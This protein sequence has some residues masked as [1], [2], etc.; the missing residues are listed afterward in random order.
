MRLMLWSQVPM[1]N[2]GRRRAH[3]L[4]FQALYRATHAG[5]TS[6]RE[7]DRKWW[8]RKRV[9]R[10]D[11]TMI[12]AL[13]AAEE[14]LTLEEVA[15]FSAGV[16]QQYSAS[17]QSSEAFTGHVLD[18]VDAIVGNLGPLQPALESMLLQQGQ[19]QRADMLALRVSITCPKLGIMVNVGD[20]WTA[21]LP[22]PVTKAF[23]FLE[24]SLHNSEFLLHPSG[25]PCLRT[26]MQGIELITCNAD[27]LFR[28]CMR[29][30]PRG[31]PRAP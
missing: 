1:Q 25:V 27:W 9:A 26:V 6:F 17:L 30:S 23:T 20:A 5:L 29:F 12:R 7:L 2:M 22:Q 10:A 11:K 13:H 24:A 16:A 14:R 8:Q 3:R 15:H 21:S 31:I 28:F 4:K 18:A 19:H